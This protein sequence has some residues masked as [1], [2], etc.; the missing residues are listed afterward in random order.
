MTQFVPPGEMNLLNLGHTMAQ[1]LSSLHKRILSSIPAIDRIA[2]ALYKEQSGMLQT[3]IHS[4]RSGSA[5][6][7]YEYPLADSPALSHCANCGEPRVIND[8]PAAL[9]TD[10]SHSSWVLRQGYL[11]S[12]TVPLYNKGRFLGFVFFDSKQDMAF[13]LEVQKDLLL[14][15]NLLAMSIILERDAIDTILASTQVA[16]EFIHLRDFETGSHLDR[17]AEYSRLI[18]GE[19]AERYNI[20]DEEIERIHLT[21]PLHDIGKIGIPDKILL[22]QGKLDEQEWEIMRTH[23]EKGLSIA[24]K[25]LEKFNLLEVA[26]SRTMLNIIGQHHEFIDGSGYPL[27]LKGDEIA[28]EAKIVIVADI[29]DALTTKRPYKE[30]WPIDQALHELDAMVAAGKLD[31]DCVGALKDNPQSVLDIMANHRDPFY[32]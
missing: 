16:N 15:S 10:T 26:E 4:T 18:A 31:A 19:L 29:F 25:V 14:H 23:V 7:G 28:I 5:L 17:M 11:S 24:R 3:Y 2:V 30:A 6:T 32:N 27:G 13:T 9:Q 12:Y 8:I 21:A 20:S 1:R 22:K